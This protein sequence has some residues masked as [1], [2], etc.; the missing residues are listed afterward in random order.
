MEPVNLLELELLARET[1]TAQ[2]FD[3]VVGGADDEVTLHENR[4]AFERYVIR[5]RML[6]DV[7]TVSTQTEVLGTKVSFPVLVAPTAFQTLAHSDGELAMAR[8]ASAEGTIMVVSTLASHRL[9]DVATAADGP[10]WFQLYCYRERSVTERLIE[11][12]EAAGYRAICLTIDVPRIGR[13]ERD[14]RNGLHMPPDAF[15][16]NF[17]DV[18]DLSSMPVEQHR[19]H[20]AAFVAGLLDASLTWEDLSWLRSITNLPLLVKGIM[21]SDDATMAIDHGVDGIVVSNHGGRQ[22]D[23]VPSTIDVLAEVAEVL[24]GRVA[25]L[26]DGGVRRGTDVLKALA[27]GA[28]AVLI[29][30]PPVFGLAWN[31]EQGAK[32]ALAMLRE[33]TELAMALAGCPSVASVTRD[34]VRELNGTRS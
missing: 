27:L 31:G 20:L 23:G 7:S 22:L 16:R 25:L 8:A 11:R 21:T 10:K 12:A 15:P 34:H 19:S 2:A 28:D 5:P 14:L 26:V 24:K 9:E 3:Y 6:V 1:M 17:E 13:R 33:E 30:R 29:G 4:R 32:R 18:T